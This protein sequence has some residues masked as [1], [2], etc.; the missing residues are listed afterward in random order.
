[1]LNEQIKEATKQ[2]HQELEKTVVYKLKAIE[3]NAD[4]ADLLKHFYVFFSGIEQQIDHLLPESLKP[5]Y[6]VRRNASHIAQDIE[7][8]GGSL[9]ELPS[10]VLPPL[11]NATQAIGALYVLEGSIMGGPYIVKMLQQRGIETGFNFF[12]GYG[13]QSHQNWAK[14]TG[15]I[16]TEVTELSAIEEAITAAQQTFSS[17][18]QTFNANILS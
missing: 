16:N 9:T 1:M 4:Y 8:L 11:H 6:A 15:I 7:A 3:N 5:Y 12:N 18:G 2:G 14:F 17:F 13:E 10:V